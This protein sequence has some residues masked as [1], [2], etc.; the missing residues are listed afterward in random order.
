VLGRTGL[1][2]NKDGFGALPVQRV[3]T[4]APALIL[5]KALDGSINFFDIARSYG[6]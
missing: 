5:R 1:E 4:A 2:V 3:D 6:Q